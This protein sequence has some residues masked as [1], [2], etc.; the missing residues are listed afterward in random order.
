MRS[1]PRRNEQFR[2]FD[3]EGYQVS[4]PLE[5]VRRSSPYPSHRLCAGVAGRG[6]ARTRTPTRSV[7]KAEGWTNRR[8]E[9][10]YRSARYQQ[11]ST[12]VNEGSV[13]YFYARHGRVISTSDENMFWGWLDLLNNER[14]EALSIARKREAT[15]VIAREHALVF[16]TWLCTRKGHYSNSFE[17][18]FIQDDIER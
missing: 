18:I 13:F 17:Y 10:Y 7:A 3:L 11:S 15:R 5:Y 9:E 4:M 2:E 8:V 6:V 1:L 12:H 14:R 16:P